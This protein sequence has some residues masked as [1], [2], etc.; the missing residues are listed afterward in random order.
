MTILT[1]DSVSLSYGVT[2]IFEDISFSINEGDKLGIIGVNGCGKST[3]LSMIYGDDDTRP[4]NGSIYIAKGKTIG[5]LRQDDPFELSVNSDGD[6]ASNTDSEATVLQQMYRAFPRLVA[7]EKRMAVLENFMANV[8]PELD[9]YARAVREHSALMQFYNE[10]GGN[11]YKSLCASVLAK[12][13]FD[14]TYHDLPV[15]SLSG[16][17]RTRLALIRLILSEP[18]ILM[19]D[20]PTNHLD[21][22]SLIW[23]EGFLSTYKKTVIVVSH[24]RYFLDRVTTKTLEIENKR[25]KLYNAPYSGYEEQK[26]AERE[27]QMRLYEQQQ[28]EIK[29]QHD[30]IEQQRCFGRERNFVTIRSREKYLERMELVD[31][32]DPL[33]KSINFKI[34]SSGRS[35]NDVLDVRGLSVAY[36]DKTVF[37]NLS[38]SV[39]RLDRLFIIGPNG[40][41]KSTLIKLLTGKLTP[42]EGVIEYGV[43]VEVYYY[44]QENQNLDPEN[45]VIEEIWSQHPKLTQTEVRSAL[46]K[47]LFI[48]DDIEKPVSVLSGGERARLTFCKLMLSPVNVLIL[49]EP[50]NH[51]DIKSREVLE[52]ALAEFKGTI[53]AVSHDRYFM[54]RLATRILPLTP[55]GAVCFEGTYSEYADYI[56]A[57]AKAEEEQ[58][59]SSQ[60]KES[61]AKRQYI[62]AKKEAAERRKREH[63]AQK[64]AAEIEAAEAELVKVES[65]LYGE[66][67]TDYIRAAELDDRRI[68]LEERLYALYEE[69]E[70]L[71]KL[72]QNQ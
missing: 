46:A 24:D 68:Q 42:K 8:S 45:T 58:N 30:I 70:A 62:N 66:A 7:A 20:E 49:D 41:G 72:L 57:K 11:Y 40:C 28:K 22:D 65:E 61:E 6:A 33:P 35:G 63:M 14:K 43:N 16:G 54:D 9:T 56:A 51:L 13:G 47:F 37:T 26:K 44:D 36:G 67:A 64:I 10:N 38:F 32:P 4:D 1:V 12:L 23:L 27:A 25:S 69:Q 55:D 71:E 48:G 53:I 2:T 31:K 17:Q 19:L 50:T 3:L 5:L 39:K 34:E 18:D 59:Q 52:A 29:R 21:M 15:S 60:N